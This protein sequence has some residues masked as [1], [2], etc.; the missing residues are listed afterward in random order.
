MKA[1]AD[2]SRKRPKNIMHDK[3]QLYEETLHL[4]N[5]CHQLEEENLRLRTK[6]SN[7]DKEAAKF[8]RMMMQKTNQFEPYKE[9]PANPKASEV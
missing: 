1:T 3:E 5:N 8:E 7:L 2:Y 4:K 9:A 6:I